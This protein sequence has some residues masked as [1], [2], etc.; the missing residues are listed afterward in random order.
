MARKRAASTQRLVIDASVARAAGGQH[1]THPASKRCRDFLQ[2]VLDVCH[3]AVV[4]PEIGAEWRRHRSRFFQLWRVSMEARK[5]VWRAVCSEQL[6]DVERVCGALATPGQ[7]EVA[8]KDLHLIKAALGADRIVV[9]LDDAAR[10]VFSL[11][12]QSCPELRTIYWVNPAHED[13]AGGWLQTEA[14][15]N[16]LRLLGSRRA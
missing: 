3:K 6:A 4:T 11:A 7:Q 10:E 16:A 2:T 1:A 12:A 8:R 15:P 5:K 13:D 9:S 14:D